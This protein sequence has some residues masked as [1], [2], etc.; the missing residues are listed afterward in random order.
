MSKLKLISFGS[1]ISDSGVNGS[2]A[3]QVQIKLII[4]KTKGLGL[5]AWEIDRLNLLRNFMIC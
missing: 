3:M 5:G 4:Q 1:T 2:Q